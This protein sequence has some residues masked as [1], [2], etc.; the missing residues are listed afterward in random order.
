MIIPVDVAA[1]FLL[2]LELTR[3]EALAAVEQAYP[4]EPEERKEQPGDHCLMWTDVEGNRMVTHYDCDQQPNGITT[5]W[6]TGVVILGPNERA[7]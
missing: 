7:K 6:K 3:E 1:A 5:E 4:E 2:G